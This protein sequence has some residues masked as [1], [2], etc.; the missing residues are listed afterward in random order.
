MLTYIAI[1]WSEPPYSLLTNTMP[2]RFLWSYLKFRYSHNVC[3]SWVH[4]HQAK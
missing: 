4:R 3:L 2:N 1:V